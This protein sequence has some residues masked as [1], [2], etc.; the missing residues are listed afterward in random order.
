MPLVPGI[1]I[2]NS[3]RSVLEN[4]YLIATSQILEALMITIMI[5]MPITFFLNILT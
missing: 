2:V 5:L 1:E 3:I 4:N